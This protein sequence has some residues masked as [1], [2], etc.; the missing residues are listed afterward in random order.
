[1]AA[2]AEVLFESRLVE[3]LRTAVVAG[4]MSELDLNGPE[5]GSMT[6]EA[7]RTEVPRS[8]VM[9]VAGIYDQVISPRSIVRMAR[10][11][12]V[13]IHWLPHGH[14]SLMTS[15][16]PIRDTVAFLQKSLTSSPL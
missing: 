3:L 9:I 10:R 12:N 14:I 2:P 8:R 16:A 15:R 7:G 5:I 4:G 6:P 11:W 13:D 1:V